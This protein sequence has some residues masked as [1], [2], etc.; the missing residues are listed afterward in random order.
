MTCGRTCQSHLAYIGAFKT[1]STYYVA[2]SMRFW[3]LSRVFSDCKY[4]VATVIVYWRLD[5]ITDS[6]QKS[7]TSVVLH[8]IF[9]KL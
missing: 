5:T 9:L 7:V 6:C 8:G 1:L 2:H 3:H 4:Y